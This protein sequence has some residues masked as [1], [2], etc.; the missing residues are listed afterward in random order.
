MQKKEGKW[1]P[2]RVLAAIGKIGYNPVSAILDIADNSVSAKCTY[3]SI[4]INP[5]TDNVNGGR[6]TVIDSITISDNG[7]G[8]T[9]AGID[10][11]ISLGSSEKYYHSGT[12]SKF[13]IGLK[14][15]ASSLSPL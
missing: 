3:L 4:N 2:S 12:L 13:G 1:H 10:N 11:A 15:A 6:R 8:M 5:K 9:E 14:S 7:N